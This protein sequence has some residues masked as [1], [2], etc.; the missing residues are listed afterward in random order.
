MSRRI[1][2][3][4]AV[5]VV[6][7]ALLSSCSSSGSSSSS[8]TA[9]EVVRPDGPAADLSQELT[10]GNG[11]FVAAATS[12][13]LAA[14]GYVEQEYVAAGTA[15][16]YAMEGPIPADGRAVARPDQTADYRT[17]IVVRRPS[18]PEAGNGTV[19]V[20]WLNVS[21]GLDAG[22]EFTATADEIIRSGSTWIGVSAQ[23]IGVEGGPV[24]VASI[25]N[26]SIGKGL[27]RID[28]ARYGSLQHPG[29][30][31]S[32][33]IYTQV[34]RAVRAGGPTD[35]LGGARPERV[36][37]VGQ[38][39][40]GF[41][42]TTYAD[43]VQPL[44]EAFDGFLIHSRGSSPLP[45]AS[46]SGTPADIRS[47]IGVPPAI[48]RTDLGV[49]VLIVETE[50]DVTS[51]LSYYDA[52]QDDTAD[53]RV[54]EVAGTAHADRSTMG[55]TADQMECGVEVNDGPQR[56]VVRAALRGLDTWVR[57]GQAPPEADRLE[58][59]TASGSPMIVRDADGIALGGIRLPQVTVPVATL[60][61]EKGPSDSTICLL[62][63]STVPFSGE[64]L[65]QL[66]P[67]ADAY[68]AAYTAATDTSIAAGFA[69]PEDRQQ[70]V[71]DADPAAISG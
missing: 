41:A 48:I 12:V 43:A 8:T 14:S 60:S 13:D 63:G 52:R 20:E 49:P 7:L 1:G 34:A 36:L 56:F 4:A 24:L 28:P 68:L 27:K 18:D 54:W 69:L 47:S 55:S 67:S 70:I 3:T 35:V 64:R 46:P 40:S 71:D 23:Q 38:S 42:L 21:G 6:A 37:A 58:V 31:F 61:G 65:T 5:I 22:P 59:T 45:L 62:L 39:Q 53:L 33:D 44:T 57:T 30:A 15:T 26:D 9:T 2:G 66:Y 11:V 19:L 16:S 10:G 50:T 32:Y 51:V 29:D 25:E 17:R